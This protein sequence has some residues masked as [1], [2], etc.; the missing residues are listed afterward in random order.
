MSNSVRTEGSATSDSPPAS[1]DDTHYVLVIHGTWNAPKVGEPAW[2]RP[3]AEDP[4]NFCTMLGDRLRGGLLEGSI[5][6]PI[7]GIKV[8]FAWSGENVHSERLKAARNL[9]KL[10]IQITQT[11]PRARI[12]LIGH[13]HGGNVILKAVEYYTNY[14]HWQ[15]GA[16]AARLFKLRAR[17]TV[18]QWVQDILPQVVGSHAEIVFHRCRNFLEDLNENIL[19][20]PSRY[21]WEWRRRWIFRDRGFE[22][23]F[24][25]VQYYDRPSNISYLAWLSSPNVDRIGKL[26]FL[27]TPFLAKSWR[28][29]PLGRRGRHFAMS[30]ATAGTLTLVSA[31]VLGVPFLLALVLILG[32]TWFRESFPSYLPASLTALAIIVAVLTIF[33]FGGEESRADTNLYFD[34]IHVKKMRDHFGNKWDSEKPLYQAL[35]VHSNL[36]DE[37]LLGLSAEPVVYALLAPRVNSFLNPD[38]ARWYSDPETT[39]FSLTSFTTSLRYLWKSLAGLLGAGVWTIFRVPVQWLFRR[40][41]IEKLLKLVRAAA[42]GL[43]EDLQSGAD[44]KVSNRIMIDEAFREASWDVTELLLIG[45]APGKGRDEKTPDGAEAVEPSTARR[46][47]YRYLFDA[48]Q[49]RVNQKQSW[50]WKRTEPHLA[51]IKKNYSRI[52]GDSLDVA[53]PRLCITLDERLREARELIELTHSLY[54]SNETVIDAVAAYLSDSRV[55]PGAVESGR[56]AAK[57]YLPALRPQERG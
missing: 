40:R 39:G 27:G 6:R 33:F 8:D 50:F 55:P 20:F 44:V 4:R 54:Y 42:M 23:P 51:E 21:P 52:H 17:P 11:D 47:L 28:P 53:L 57:R 12:H 45:P 22:R 7:N 24:K 41:I 1:L 14:L 16:I 25:L 43:P 18:D 5:L 9:C 2:Y 46:D 34:Q 36:L 30:F 35:V 10:I 19:S 56:D 38:V 26:V 49:V 3:N 31:F 13:S 37:A 48:P 15:A 32:L 29:S